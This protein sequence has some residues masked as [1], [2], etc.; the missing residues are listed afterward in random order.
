MFITGPEVVRTVTGEDVT[1]EELGG[2]FTHAS[3]SGVAHFIAPDDVAC[4]QRCGVAVV[5]PS[6]NG[7]APA[8]GHPNDSPDRL[9]L[10]GRHRPD[11]PNHP[12]DMAQ[13]IAAV[14]DDASCRV[15]LTLGPQPRLWF[16]PSRRPSRRQSSATRRRCSPAFRIDSSEK[17]ARLVSTCE[18]S[19]SPHRLRRCAGV[20]SRY[21]QGTVGSSATAPSSLYAF[22]A[23]TVPRVQVI[24]RKAYGGAYVVMNS[25]SV[26]AILRFAL[27]V[28]G[29]GGMGP[30]GAVELLHRRELRRLTTR[31]RRPSW[32]RSKTSVSTTPTSRRAW[33][34]RRRSRAIG[35]RQL[36]IRTAWPCFARSARSSLGGSMATSPSDVSGYA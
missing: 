11:R 24:T 26:G 17:G 1:L 2:A 3:R 35:H 31:L 29:A 21:R 36:L 9:V 10:S 19:P 32:F 23:A 18:P 4:L 22:C 28:G 6:N 7:E 13:V 25:K 12:Y 14:V 15:L 16:R 8:A 27:A 34:R 5:S 20:P 33:V 30:H